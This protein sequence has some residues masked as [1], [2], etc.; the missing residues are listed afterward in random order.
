MFRRSATACTKKKKL[1]VFQ[2]NSTRSS[3][4]SS[5]DDSVS[6]T[7][8]SDSSYTSSHSSSQD[9]DNTLNVSFKE[10]SLSSKNFTITTATSKSNTTTTIN[11]EIIVESKSSEPSTNMHPFVGPMSFFKTERG[12]INLCMIGFSY[13]K[14]KELKDQIKW[15][16]CETRNN[17]VKCPV[18]LYTSYNQGNDDHPQYNFKKVTGDHNHQ[19]D[20]D[21]LIIQKFKSDLKQMTQSSTVP[22]SIATYNQLAATMKLGRSQMAQL[23]PF[24]S[25]RM[26]LWRA[27]NRNMPQLPT[28]INS[29]IPADFS[30]TTDDKPFI[31]LDYSYAKRTKRILMCS[32][33]N[34]NLNFAIT[35]RQFKQTYITQ[36]HDIESNQ[37]LPV[38]WILLN[39]KKGITYKILFK[40]IIALAEKRGYKFCPSDIMSDYESGIISTLKEL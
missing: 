9:S 15:W 38:A 8:S 14:V 28:D 22:P 10:M 21:K 11:P 25:I 33:R 4:S 18:L 13:Q 16:C 19:P 3:S 39:D 40:K 20:Q 35:P 12:G 31:L 37:V 6:S 29:H 32:H 30:T 36:A 24:N 23:P 27:H 2:L 26:T 7:S 5:S 1:K 34:N 17:P